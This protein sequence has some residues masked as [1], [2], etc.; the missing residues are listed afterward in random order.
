MSDFNDQIKNVTGKI[1]IVTYL[2]MVPTK[3]ESRMQL[4]REVRENIRVMDKYNPETF[5]KPMSY[6]ELD[7]AVEQVDLN[8]IQVGDR[9]VLEV[10]KHAVDMNDADASRRMIEAQPHFM[11]WFKSNDIIDKLN[12]IA[13]K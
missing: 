10:L 8:Q 12:L 2:A 5:L 6:S 9:L 7:A 13:Y 4:K 11:S 3:Y 1:A